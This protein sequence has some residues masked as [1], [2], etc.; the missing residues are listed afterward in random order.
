MRI[1][2]TLV[3][4]LVASACTS[5]AGYIT[6]TTTTTIG[7]V[8]PYDLEL[9]ATYEFP[10]FGFV[11]DYPSGWSTGAFGTASIIAS[12][13][14][15]PESGVPPPDELDSPIVAFEYRPSLRQFGP[16]A[17]PADLVD[18]NID[19]FEL[20]EP[21]ER[22]DL[23]IAGAPAIA[24]RTTDGSGNHIL[25]LQG[26]LD[27]QPYYLRLIVPDANELEALIPTWDAMLASVRPAG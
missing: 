23:L 11:I 27:G 12:D 10:N 15:F 7:N 1:V 18:Y 13:P 8:A 21:N 14:E 6:E 17:T 20:A 9:D 16:A 5:A 19:F 24:V 4:V 3:L 26:V 2:W 22:T 25:M